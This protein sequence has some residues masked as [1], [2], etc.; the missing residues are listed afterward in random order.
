M[1][2]RQVRGRHR[3]LLTAEVQLR[4]QGRIQL[5]LV[6]VGH[7]LALR[8]RRKHLRRR[9]RSRSSGRRSSNHSSRLT[10]NPTRVMRGHMQ[11]WRLLRLP[12]LEV[13]ASAQKSRQ[14]QPKLLHLKLNQRRQQREKEQVLETR[15]RGGLLKQGLISKTQSRARTC[16]QE[17][18][19]TRHRPRQMLK[20]QVQLCRVRVTHKPPRQEELQGMRKRRREMVGAA[21][22][23]MRLSSSHLNSTSD[24]GVHHS[25]SLLIRSF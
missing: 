1:R 6:L 16:R 19:L 21:W 7:N 4:W 17:Q 11:S 18:A 20:E 14:T 13:M 12:C 9:L 22:L 5:S 25:D 3:L 10:V 2:S 8:R 23:L 15:E 24:T